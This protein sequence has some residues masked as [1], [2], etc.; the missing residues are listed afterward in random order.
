MQRIT[1]AL[2][3]ALAAIGVAAC[4]SSSS[5]SSSTTP[6]ASSA[7][8]GAGPYGAPTTTTAAA[9]QAG[10][11][12]VV[13]T[14]KQKL[15]TFLA[16]AKGLTLYEFEADKGASSACSGACAKVWPP[17]TTQ[18]SPTAKKAA[19]AGDLGT[20][21]RA[22]GTTQVTYAGHPLYYYVK[23]KDSGDHYGQ[24]INSFGAAWYVVAPSGKKI[25]ES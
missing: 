1:P 20:F 11:A 8:T 3:A 14:K 13:S 4:G 18:G 22:D 15:G 10:A 19:A 17:L 9:G 5:S 2:I 24:G 23:D 21:K 7:S 25:D 16:G 6:A 12:A